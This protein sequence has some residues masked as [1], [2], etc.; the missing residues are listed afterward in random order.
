MK[1]I[2]LFLFTVI[3]INGCEIFETEDG[4]NINK[5][6]NCELPVGEFE[7]EFFTTT[8]PYTE[9]EEQQDQDHDGDVVTRVRIRYK[10][11]APECKIFDQRCYLVVAT[12]IESTERSPGRFI[13]NPGGYDYFNDP[14]FD[15]ISEAW[16]DGEWVEKEFFVAICDNTNPQM[17]FSFWEETYVWSLAVNCSGSEFTFFGNRE[18]VLVC[19]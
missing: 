7:Y 6:E 15:V 16:T 2:L 1:N 4:I 9:I 18:D 19:D 10:A 17:D 3:V 5:S 14:D 11:T 13:L 12:N 8:G